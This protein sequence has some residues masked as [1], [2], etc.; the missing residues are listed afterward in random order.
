[1]DSASW[2]LL[3]LI[4]RD[5]HP[6]LL[7]IITRPLAEPLPKVY[8]YIISSPDT[9][10][11]EM[12]ALSK[13][14]SLELVCQQFGV[15]K[16]ADKVEELI[17]EKSQGNP[18][19]I[20]ELAKRLLETEAVV[21]QEGLCKLAKG[22][23]DLDSL[24]LPDTLEG[25]ITERIDRLSAPQQLALK[26]ASV[27]GH[28]FRL[29]VLRDIFPLKEERDNLK[30]FLDDL[31][32][33]DLMIPT[34]QQAE[35][36]YVFKQYLTGEVAYNMLLFSQR[37]QL[38]TSVAEWYER[39]SPD[40]LAPFYSLLVYHFSRVG[41]DERT[42][43]YCVKA[44][45]QAAN[46]F[47]NLEALKFYQQ[48]IELDRKSGSPTSDLVRGEW[49][50]AMGEVY[51]S[52]ANFQQS[53][54][55]L[56]IALS[57]LGQPAD[58]SKLQLIKELLKD[59]GRQF[60]HRLF[61]RKYLGRKHLQAQQLLASARALERIAQIAYMGNDKPVVLYSA[62]RALNLSEEAGTSPELARCLANIC[63]V[64]SMI[65]NYKL[66]E[67]YSRLSRV[68]AIQTNNL[69]CQAY[70]M[71]L[72][73]IFKTTT[74]HWQVIKELLLPAIRIA[75]R[76]G[77][78]RRWDELMF[79]LAPANY[80]RGKHKQ[81]AQEF[82]EL[83][84]SGHRRGIVQIQAWGLTGIIYSLISSNNTMEAE[85]KLKLI[86]FEKLNIADQAMV[87]GVLAHAAYQRGDIDNA[88][89]HAD[90]T[91]M[92]IKGADAV[93]QYVLEGL[94]GASEVF[95]GLWEEDSARGV[96]M[97]GPV[98]ILL[99]SLRS[100]SKTNTVGLPQYYRHLGREAWLQ[101]KQSLAMKHWQYGL[102]KASELDMRYEQALLHYEIGRHSNGETSRTHLMQ[103][104]DSFDIIGAEANYQQVNKLLSQ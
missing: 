27:I 55:H 80:R 68:T 63:V 75:E 14:E 97:K 13:S 94:T 100:Y 33:L 70:S 43:K 103:A 31:V 22:I 30:T 56:Q 24:N 16:L 67:M 53:R 51:Y 86:D 42:L 102:E 73:A 6:L 37:E 9:V 79:T 57:L 62:L 5:V 35:Q 82:E 47:A 92:A 2:A 11:I 39:T 46:T 4:I 26:V 23:V 85:E 12:A 38:H 60:L 61:S 59:V 99:K 7:F 90:R 76:I 45:Y 71:M 101:D 8:R 64:S 1:V 15:K 98:Q 52:L 28:A 32:R 49:H 50:L 89:L 19:F 21:I 10:R 87:N 40:N 83:Y 58:L 66:A 65:P 36:S 72:T 96:V 88:K 84:E 95:L 48:A 29:N 25:L 41:D 3:R 74:G 18:F 77:D 91:V 17:N 34:K 54:E 44:G 81:A 78:H 104:R 93:A 20:E 69:Q